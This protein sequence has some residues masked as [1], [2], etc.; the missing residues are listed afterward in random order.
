MQMI[1][2][3]SLARRFAFTAEYVSTCRIADQC[4]EAEGWAVTV[5]GMSGMDGRELCS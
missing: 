4:S 5:T 1:G 2:S 3:Y